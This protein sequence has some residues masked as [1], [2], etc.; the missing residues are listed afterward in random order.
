MKPL[1]LIATP[2][3]NRRL[4]EILGLAMLVAAILLLIS[5]ATY[6]PSDPSLDTVGAYTAEAATPADNWTGLLGAFLADA[7]LQL[8]GVAAFF[9]PIVIGRTA[10][11]WLRSPPGRLPRRPQHRSRSLDRLRPCRHRHGP[12]S[13]CQTSPLA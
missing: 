11:C 8:I 12:P 9:L 5:L 3:R 1:R 4:N 13:V 6:T 7:L 2:T 10:Y